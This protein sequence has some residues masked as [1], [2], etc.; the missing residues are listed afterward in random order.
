MANGGIEKGNYVQGTVCRVLRKRTANEPGFPDEVYPLVE[1]KVKR[2]IASMQALDEDGEPD[3]NDAHYQL[4]AYA[5]A[6]KV[7]TQYDNLDGKDVE[8][9]VFAVRGKPE[10]SDFETA[11]ERALGIACNTLIPRELDHSWRFPSLVERYYLRALGI[12]SQGERRKGMVE[13]LARGFGVTDIEPLLKSD[14]ANG[15]RIF[16]AGGMAAS[17]LVPVQGGE[18]GGGADASALPACRGRAGSAGPHPFAASPLRHPMFAIRETSAT[19]NN[20]EPGRQYLRDTF[21]Q[22][23]WG[24]REAFVVL[25]EWLAALGNA[26]GMHEWI[27]LLAP[28]CESSRYEV[29]IF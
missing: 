26:E 7:L 2:Q 22:G 20:P 8:H 13:E 17:L 11:I 1:D 3:F 23:Y 9:E 25:L 4:A 27:G 18:Q 16:T 6:L 15:T 5:A 10:K 28:L 29:A 24:K 19:D 21:G 12:E 14:K